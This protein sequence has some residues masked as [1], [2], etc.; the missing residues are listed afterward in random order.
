MSIGWS[1]LLVFIIAYSILGWS[2]FFMQPSFLYHPVRDVM[3]NPGDIDLAYEKVSLTAKDGVKL[4]AWYI[5]AKRARFTIL[6]CHGNGGNISHRLDS[7]NIFNEMGLNC[8]IFDYRGYGNSQGKPSESGTYMDA[9]AAYDWLTNIKKI[10]PD[11]IILF[12]RSLGGAIASN[13]ASKVRARGLILESTFTSF[14]DIGSKFYPYMPVRLFAA[15][16]YKTVEFIRKIDMPVLIIH[17]RTDETVPFE[18]GLRLYDVASEPKE[19]LEIYG[20]HNDGFLF[21]GDTYTQ[22]LNAWLEFV[23]KYQPQ[24][25]SG[26]RRITS[27]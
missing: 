3:Y 4:S 5:P 6:F 8:F 11:E 25:T 1:I 22:G 2:L 27:A 26:I 15:F 24:V 12:G 19:F 10:R 13:L 20:C 23:E 7:I 9:E 16:S 17:S 18:F 21:S 14:P